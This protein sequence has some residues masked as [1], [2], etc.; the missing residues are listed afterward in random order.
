MKFARA[1]LPCQLQDVDSIDSGAGDNCDPILGGSHQLGK[2][3]RPLG[4]AF[5]ASRGENPVR[6]GLDDSFECLPQIGGLVKRA[7]KCHRQRLRKLNK[8]PRSLDVNSM[9]FRQDAQYDTIHARFFGA[10]D[11]T[12]HF[13]ELSGRIDEVSGARPDHHKNGQAHLCAH[14]AEKISVRG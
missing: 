13:R 12:F 11:G 3:G 5:R 8:L 6:A 2:N 9:V 1:R 10:G 14:S 4:S 7:V